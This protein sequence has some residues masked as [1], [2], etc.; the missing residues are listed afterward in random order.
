VPRWVKVLRR[1]DRGEAAGDAGDSR[2]DLVATGNRERAAGKEVPLDV[3][4]QERVRVA[5]DEHV[6]PDQT[7][8]ANDMPSAA[9][10]SGLDEALLL[11]LYELTMAEA[12]VDHDMNGTASFEL[13]VRRFPR[14]R[15]FLI[16]AGLEQALDFLESFR[17]SEA[18]RARLASSG[19]ASRRLLER[20]ADFRFSG[21]VW[22]MPE[23]T[24]FF[25]HEPLLRVTAPLPEAQLAETRLI[26]L[27]HFQT[28]VASKAA[29]VVLAASGRKI[30]D[31]GLRRAHGDEAGVL[32]ARATYVAGFDGTSNVLAGAR[33][34]I[35]TY[36]TM[37]HSFVQTHDDEATAFENFARSQPDNVVLLI[38][39]YDTEA[40]AEKVVALAPRLRAQG[41]AVK[42]VRIDS[43]DLADHARK[44]R[45]I[46]DAGGLRSVEI[47]ASSGLDEHSIAALVRARAPIETFAPGT[48]VVTSAD[49]PFLDCAYKLV[50][51]EGRPRFKRSEG[52]VTYPGCKQ[53]WRT[54]D[55]DG[56]I[57]RERLAL[58]DELAEHRPLLE[59]VMEGGRRLGRSPPLET[60]RRRAAREVASLPAAFRGLEPE[61]PPPS[62]LTISPR[63]L[64][65]LHGGGPP[66]GG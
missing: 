31:F 10:G 28:I 61:A 1:H 51:Y 20:L 45:A 42:G 50:E 65:L 14:E 29:R 23:G 63:I 4:H 11:D 49:A 66:G 17:F 58:A 30:I 52:K 55:E 48:R 34:G 12:Y 46:L 53:V 43:G 22:A 41:I 40:A 39:T 26:N 37:A 6:G 18:A 36:G 62:L 60:V 59:K 16:A 38:D 27:L 13:S 47:V 33:F 44:V 64:A 21:D 54:L 24:V 8:G 15:R 3:H 32:A 57:A 2:K 25:P 19:R 5:I 9:E 7:R 35:P 56:V